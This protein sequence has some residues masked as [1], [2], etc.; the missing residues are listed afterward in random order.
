[1]EDLRDIQ[2]RVRSMEENTLVYRKRIRNLHSDSVHLGCYLLDAMYV[3]DTENLKRNLLL[4]FYFRL[5]SYHA[6]SAFAS[7]EEP[8]GWRG[9][10]RGKRSLLRHCKLSLNTSAAQPGLNTRG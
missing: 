9:A 3:T 7:L 10:P 4:G 5:W 6:L 2:A 1:M 8:L